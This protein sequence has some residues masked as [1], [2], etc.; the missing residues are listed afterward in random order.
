MDGHRYGIL[1]WLALSGFMSYVREGGLIGVRAQFLCLT[2]PNG[3]PSIDFNSGR[4][5]MGCVQ[6]Y[7]SNNTN[8]EISKKV[9]VIHQTMLTY[10]L[11]TLTI[12]IIVLP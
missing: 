4:R 3:G 8:R 10:L 5:K 1:V 7:E 12:A 9:W 11:P 6:I 2:E